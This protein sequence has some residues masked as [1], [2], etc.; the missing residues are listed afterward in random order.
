[1]IRAG[2][3]TCIII[4]FYFHIKT[5]DTSVFGAYVLFFFRVFSFSLTSLSFPFGCRFS[6]SLFQTQLCTCGS[7]WQEI[8]V[9]LDVCHLR[10]PSVL[11]FFCHSLHA[12][13]IIHRKLLEIG[14]EIVRDAAARGDKHCL[15][16]SADRKA[17]I[18]NALVQH[19]GLIS[20]IFSMG[21]TIEDGKGVHLIICLESSITRHAI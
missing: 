14:K 4:N 10:T 8:A 11:Y 18:S 1:M 9:S 16:K 6:L 5:T 2:A 13:I 20:F 21:R 19:N 3:C 17:Q 12:L 7:R 15:R